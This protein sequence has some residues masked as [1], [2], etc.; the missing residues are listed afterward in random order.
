MAN[1]YVCI[2]TNT[3]KDVVKCFA[4]SLPFHIKLSSRDLTEDQIKKH[5]DEYA[6]LW[7]SQCNEMLQAIANDISYYLNYYS[8]FAKGSID[9]FKAV[10]FTGRVISRFLNSRGLNELREFNDYVTIALL[11]HKMKL[12]TK[13]HRTV[14][15]K[16]MRQIARQNQVEDILGN[17]GM[18]MTY[19]VSCNMSLGIEPK[20]Y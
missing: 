9:E 15:T 19:K 14:L 7:E 18:Y 1:P 8:V 16:S 20:T 5:V 11:D 6:S 13:K 2:Y 12:A 4:E 10:Y 17:H 3:I